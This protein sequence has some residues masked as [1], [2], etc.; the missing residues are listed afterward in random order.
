MFL[1][2]ESI[3][4][5]KILAYKLWPTE[6]KIVL[7]INVGSQIHFPESTSCSPV[8]VPDTYT[9]NTMRDDALLVNAG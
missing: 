7:M 3:L 9:A 8:C 6:K 1:Y 4:I 2:T 5:K